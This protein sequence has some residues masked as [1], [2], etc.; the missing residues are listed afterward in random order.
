MVPKPSAAQVKADKFKKQIRE[1]DAKFL[2]EYMELGREKADRN[3]YKM[4]EIVR[5]RIDKSMRE[6]KGL[7][8]IH[9][10]AI[11]KTVTKEN[12]VA[13]LTRR[14]QTRQQ[15]TEKEK[16]EEAERNQRK[17]QEKEDTDR[18]AK[19]DAKPKEEIIKEA[20]EGSRGS[21]AA[22]LKRAR[23]LTKNK[24]TMDDVKKW[25]LENTNKEKKT[26]RK[27]FN[28]WVANTRKEEYQVDLFFFQ[29]L[30]KK[31]AM[32]EL[33]EERAKEGDDEA[34]AAITADIPVPDAFAL[35]EATGGARPKAKAEP[36]LSR[37]TL[38]KAKAEPKAKAAPKVSARSKE[39][40]LIIKNLS[41]EFESGLLVVDTFTKMIAVV[42]MKNR[43]WETLKPSLETAFNR[44]GGKPYA[45]YSDAEA[46]LTGYE[47]AGYFQEQEIVHNITLGHAPIA[48]RMIGV[49]KERIVHQLK[50]PWQMWWNYVDDVVKEYNS[51]NV[52]RSTKMTP[53]E[54]AKEENQQEVKT[55]LESI[56]KSD[57]PQPVIE[58]GDEVRV[59]V[60][61]KFDKSYVPDWTDKT[62]KV[63][64]KQEWNHVYLHDDTPKDPQT[65][66]GLSDPTNDLPRY[67]DRFMRHELLRVK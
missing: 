39:L 12:V 17:K 20:F 45:I 18:S 41:W 23:L 26:D 30:K 46:A 59:M 34:K 22:T 58:K 36:K 25:R 28:S 57:N 1:N 6:D 50:E 42:P 15:M 5:Q 53:N 49:I 31:L 66:Y 4:L 38:S 40:Q 44:L 37:M 55:N 3:V 48:E 19:W 11:A 67:K 2:D 54:A 21:L 10:E 51:E 60:K 47:A 9:A 64:K 16:R 62:Y 43:D 65:M 32:K 8:W 35:T 24:I 29:D 14:L 27:A 33:L 13:W 61:K 56:R 63:T 52:S 7:G